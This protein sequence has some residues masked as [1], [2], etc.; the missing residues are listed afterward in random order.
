MQEKNIYQG[1]LWKNGLIHQIPKITE[2][3]QNSTTIGSN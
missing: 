2:N 1:F 3:C